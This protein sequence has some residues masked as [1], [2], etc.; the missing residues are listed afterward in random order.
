MNQELPQILLLARRRPDP[1]E[2]SFPKEFQNQLGIPAIV[3]LSAHV[4]GANFCS[5]PDP[6]VVPQRCGH[7][8]NPL[9][10]SG[11]LH[12]D[13]SRRG[14]LP[15]KPLRFSRGMLQLFFSRLARG[16]VQP[17]NLLPTG[18][19]ITSNKHHRRLLPTES[20]GPP[21]RSL[22]G[23]RTEPSFLSNQPF[24]LRVRVLS[25]PRSSCFHI[26]CLV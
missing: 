19:V 7:F 20:F 26:L 23:Y 5:V 13:Q 21:T 18:V 14:Q 17:T 15:I 2:A 3:F 8:H 16:R 4:P 10:I 22:L 12:P 25:L 1:R 9:T 11:R 6:Q 24:G